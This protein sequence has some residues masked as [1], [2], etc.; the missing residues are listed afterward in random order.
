MPAC[1]YI[2]LFAALFFPWILSGQIV[3]AQA[4]SRTIHDGPPKYDAEPIVI[5]HLDCVYRMQA[6]GTGVEERSASARIQ[7]EAALKQVAVLSVPFAA[8]SQRVEWI[9]ARIRHQDGSSTETPIGNVIEVAEQV[10]REAP[11][12]S[13]LKDSQLPIRDLRV[14]DHLEW[15][16]RTVRSKAEAP[17]QFWGSHAFVRNGVLLSETLELD[18]P[19]GMPVNVWSPNQKAKESDEGDR[20]LYRWVNAELKPTVGSDAEAFKEAETKRV[21]TADEELDA[22]LGK[23][24]DVAWTTF[25]SWEAVGAWYRGLEGERMSPD[26]EVKAKVAQ[27]TA[28]KTTDSAKVQ[29]VYSYV[30]TQI[31]YVGVA[32][33]IGR[34][35]PHSANDVLGNQYGDCKDKHTLLAAMLNALNLRPEAV[36]IGVGIRFNP[37]VP[38]PAAF[39][40]LMTRVV[41]DGKPVWLDTTA[42][43]APFG[44]LTVLTRDHEAL[45]V[46]EDGAAKVERTPAETGFAQTQTMVASGKLDAEGVSLSRITMTFHGDTELFL[47]S[48]LRQLSPAQYDQFIQQL[49]ASMGYG[50]TGSHLEVSRVDDTT[51]PLR[52]SFDY[53]REKGGDWPNLK[54]IPQLA[55]VGLPIP[56]ESDPPVVSLELGSPRVETSDAAMTLPEGWRAELPEAV[57]ERSTWVT[58]D[59]TYR[60]EKG[61]VHA[62]RKIE[63]FKERVPVAEWKT[64]SKFAEKAN[65]SGE[66]YVQL[67]R[68]TAQVKDSGAT[69][70][71]ELEP[72][73]SI[74]RPTDA[75]VS[76]IESA[77]EGNANPSE[78]LKEG[79]TAL[80]GRNF[81]RARTL[82]DEVK[83]KSPEQP[84]VWALSGA[85]FVALGEVSQGVADM[86]KELTLHPSEL[87][88][89]RALA[90][91][92]QK[93]GYRADAKETLARWSEAAPE[94][95]TPEIQLITLQ[96]ADHEPSIAAI[97]AEKALPRTASSGQPNETLE[98]LL[99]RAQLRSDEREKGHL[100][101][102]ALLRKTD[103]P[104]LMNDTAYE[105]ANVGLELALA[106]QKTRVALGKMEEESR[107]WTLD[108]NARVLRRKTVLLQATWDTM[109]WIYFHEGKAK[110]AERY[111]RAAWL[112]RQDVEVGKHLA[113]LD[114]AH[115]DR[116]AALLDY[117]LAIATDPGYDL[118]GVRRE[119]GPETKELI[120]RAEALR[121]AG[122]HSGVTNTA[123]ALAQVR[124]LPLGSGP[125]GVA[126]YRLLLNAGGVVRAEPTGE[127]QVPEAL[128]K[129]KRAKMGTYFPEGSQAHLVFQGVVNC[130]SG[131]CELVLEP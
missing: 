15:K 85:V 117:E 2:L 116:N 123:A 17:G 3:F 71:A 7:S 112:G 6:D 58:Y 88:M 8:N 122:A 73:T 76:A 128:A 33:G 50:G 70:T 20:H 130:H 84:G 36:L 107:S 11:F 24:P 96:L 34:F 82:V 100:T 102:A 127:K 66:M 52:L 14:G 121:K 118:R 83:A 67:V 59:L 120:D 110:Q 81:V 16:A 64:Y 65:L 27:V 62:E 54:V 40:H 75:E 19:R 114:E 22:R 46:P 124:K 104:N 39:N 89:Y 25:K 111:V 86:K 41:L 23:L 49:C 63:V 37:G 4:V 47:R 68:T 79:Y 28:G 77:A 32:F 93:G 126:E 31:H 9:Y 53:K 108:E 90:E 115:G 87:Q 10:T 95:P 69:F 92:Q 61:T 45:V 1:R 72:K 125:D 119:P 56:N 21:R 103:E 99:G 13:D 44:M 55:P 80:Q 42:E 109:G 106:E 60:F 30:A 74:R 12:Y 131:E 94:D 129:L 78:L 29:A 97:R 101:L 91:A 35:Q 5:E 38:S 51:E 105:L 113:E 48:V 18:V 26:A 57:H 98:L 43:V